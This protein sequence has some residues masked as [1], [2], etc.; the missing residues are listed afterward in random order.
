VLC[1]AKAFPAAGFASLA[2][3]DTASVDAAGSERADCE[4]V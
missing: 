4:V 1:P 3:F 2:P